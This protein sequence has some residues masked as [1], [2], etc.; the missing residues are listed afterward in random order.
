[1]TPLIA[2][3]CAH[4]VM[5]GLDPAISRQR[6]IRGSSPRMTNNL[7]KLDP[8]FR[9]GDEESREAKTFL[10]GLDLGLSSRV[11]DGRVKPGHDEKRGAR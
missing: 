9:Q 4:R 5:A 11:A 6:Q 8:N 3:P 1:M 2:I 7:E 10:P